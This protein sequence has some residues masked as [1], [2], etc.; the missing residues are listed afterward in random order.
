[1]C[2]PV[3]SIPFIGEWYLQTKDLGAREGDHTPQF[4]QDEGVSW[5]VGLWS[6]R[7]KT[8]ALPGARCAHCC[9]GVPG[10]SQEVC[11]CVHCHTRVRTSVFISTLT[12]MPPFAAQQ[13]SPWPPPAL[14]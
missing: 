12:L 3:A 6:G 4:A 10:Q 5:G 11:V 8:G 2:S 13:G 1:M 7:S 14:S 9:L